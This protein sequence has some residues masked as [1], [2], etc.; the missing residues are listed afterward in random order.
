MSKRAAWVITWGWFA[1]TR[2]PHNLL[3]HIVP[4]QW[5]CGRVA[6]YLKRLYMNSEFFPVSER[7]DFFSLGEGWDNFLRLEGPRILLGHDPHLRASLVSELRTE[8]D[9][10]SGAQIVRWTQPPGTTLSRPN[11]VAKHHGEPIEKVFRISA[12]GDI[13][14]LKRDRHA[15]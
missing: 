2:K 7:F 10:S 1:T 11:F 5:G 9:Q 14:E 8:R 12:D 3:L 15:R 6:D 13:S 4:P